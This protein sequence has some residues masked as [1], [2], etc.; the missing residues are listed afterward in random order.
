MAL[1]KA[2]RQ[3]HFTSNI[4]KGCTQW[5]FQKSQILHHVLDIIALHMEDTKRC[6]DFHN[7]MPVDQ[8]FRCRDPNLHHLKAVAVRGD[9]PHYD[10]RVRQGSHTLQ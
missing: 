1:V 6:L 7:L 10:S 4:L 3:Y 8:G 5:K 9:A 2:L